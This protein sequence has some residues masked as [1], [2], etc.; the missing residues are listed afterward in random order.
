MSYFV[1]SAFQ[2]KNK[3]PKSVYFLKYLFYMCT[4]QDSNLRPSR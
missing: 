4:V 1:K 2:I 3:H